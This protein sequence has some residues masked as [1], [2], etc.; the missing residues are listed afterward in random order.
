MTWEKKWKASEQAFQGRGRQ[1]H[2]DT[3]KGVPPR[4][5]PARHPT[6]QVGGISACPVMPV[7]SGED[8]A[9]DTGP[10]SVSRALQPP[11]GNFL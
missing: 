11:L 6:Q 5:Q 8:T 2:L 7:N 10:T 3:R 4:Y 9:G 1:G